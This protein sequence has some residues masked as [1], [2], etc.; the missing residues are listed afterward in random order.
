MNLQKNKYRPKI[1]E[2][3]AGIFCF[4]MQKVTKGLQF[5]EK[6]VIISEDEKANMK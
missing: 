5:S 4:G 6:S 1:L 2:K 3:I